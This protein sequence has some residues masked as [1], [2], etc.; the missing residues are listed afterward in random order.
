[1][2]GLLLN[3]YNNA[4]ALT[5]F[6]KSRSIRHHLSD[7]RSGFG[8]FGGGFMRTIRTIAELRDQLGAYRRNG[9][10][11]GFVPTMGFLHVGHMELVAC[12][13]SKTT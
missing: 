1:M 5:L 11:I 8:E 2:P 6:V 7:L 12:A 9:K 3:R 13:R 10:T 4:V